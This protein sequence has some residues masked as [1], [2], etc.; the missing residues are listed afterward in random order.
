MTFA[1]N[2]DMWKVETLI[3]INFLKKIK[4]KQKLA[5]LELSEIQYKVKKEL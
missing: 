1:D 3:I 4:I 5:P 2:V